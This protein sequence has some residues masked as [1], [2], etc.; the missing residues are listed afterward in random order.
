MAYAKFAAGVKSNGVW[1]MKMQTKKHHLTGSMC[2]RVFPFIHL[3]N[4]SMAEKMQMFP[5]TIERIYLGRECGENVNQQPLNKHRNGAVKVF[6]RRF[7]LPSVNRNE[8]HIYLNNGTS[9]PFSYFASSFNQNLIWMLCNRFRFIEITVD[10]R[11]H[12]F[13]H[14]IKFNAWAFRI[15]PF[16]SNLTVYGGNER[17]YFLQPKFDFNKNE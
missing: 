7:S 16:E 4:I 2:D 13:A 3:I 15:A 12:S 14:A 8:R 5:I 9:F 17:I 10:W 6:S 1:F 11:D